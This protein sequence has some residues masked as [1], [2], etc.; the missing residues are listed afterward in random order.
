[1]IISLIFNKI[2]PWISRWKKVPNFLKYIAE[3]ILRFKISFFTILFGLFFC[4]KDVFNPLPDET[5]YKRFLGDFVN[6]A[7]DD[8]YGTI[9]EKNLKRLKAAYEKSWECRDFEINKFWSRS[10]FFWGFIVLIF[11]GYITLTTNSHNSHYTQIKYLDFY[12][13]LLGF[14]FSL[15]W[16]LV[17]KGSKAWQENWEA[18]IDHLENFISGPLYKTV[19]YS[20]EYKFYSV[21]K[22]NV[23]LAYISICVWVG[24]IFQYISQYKFCIPCLRPD[25]DDKINWHITISLFITF[26][27][28]AVLYFGY[29]AGKYIVIQ[30]EFQ[31]LHDKNKKGV[32]IDRY[33]D[34][35]N[36]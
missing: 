20:K 32:F 10:A 6:L 5:Y 25:W 12:L 21:S 16:L 8:N 33:Q 22:I 13:M 36:S 9:D 29:P 26:V 3:N 34:R 35:G 17:I 11:T 4:K 24:M 1:M 27:F 28:A 31:K 2:V 23:V 30:E 18:H 19:W 7:S 15:A 14:L